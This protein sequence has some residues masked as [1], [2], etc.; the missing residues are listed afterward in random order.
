M[1]R[2]IPLLYLRGRAAL[3]RLALRFMSIRRIWQAWLL[4]VFLA[5]PPALTAAQTADLAEIC[6]LA[7]IQAAKATGVPLSV[8][9]AISLNE[10]G[11]K[12]DGE[13]RPWPWT[14][15]MEGKGV[16]FDN[17]DEALA[18]AYDHFK[19]GARSF[20]VGCFQINYKWHHQAFTSI[21]QMFEPLANALYAAEFLNSL[22]AEFG[23]WE[24]AAG[25]YHS[26]N[27]AFADK[28]AARFAKFRS[29][30]AAEDG[31][32]LPDVSPVLLAAATAGVDPLLR[33]Q[34][35]RVNT[36]PLLQGG[37]GFALGSLVPQSVA[38]GLSLVGAASPLI[39]G[40]APLAAVPDLG[41]DP[42]LPM[43]T[44]AAALGP[45]LPDDRMSAIGAIY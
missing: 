32:P 2:I 25:A 6:D 29:R 45:P 3:W 44:Q 15:N 9:K 39:G 31:L 24:K 12:S 38:A 34:V 43:P 14:V 7:A 20:D 21:D 19:A 28:Y 1:V 10:T 11:R 18:Y 13:F 41:I 5:L 4:A 33:E 30:F 37:D 36:Y 27:P 35:I 42:A 17:R 16:W 23:T 22:F 8:L 40:A 26:R